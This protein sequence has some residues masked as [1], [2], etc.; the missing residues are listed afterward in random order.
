MHHLE[1]IKFFIKFGDPKLEPEE[2]ERFAQRLMSELREMDEVNSVARVLDPHP[3]DGIKA[4]GGN[5]L[6]LLTA[7]VSVENAR[8][9]LGFLADR[10]GKKS[11]ELEV[12]AGGKKLKVK[13]HG[14]EELAIAIKEAKDFIG[15]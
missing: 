4:F 7:E 10:L 15:E 1:N 11:I 3:P 2:Q 8:K 9:L 5:V 12:E 14:R 6:G 13:A